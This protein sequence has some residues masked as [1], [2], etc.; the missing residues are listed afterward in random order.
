MLPIMKSTLVIRSEGV[1]QNC[2]CNREMR[3][4]L[5]EIELAN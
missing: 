4:K 5:M 2:E 3:I 1:K